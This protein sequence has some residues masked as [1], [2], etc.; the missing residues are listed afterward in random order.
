MRITRL[1]ATL[2]FTLLLSLTGTLA[3]S[4]TEPSLHQVYEAAQS[5]HLEQAQEM[6]S[7]VLK[8]HPN[9]AKAHFVRAEL[10]S[11]QGQL[12]NARA[13][14][15]TAERLAPGLP[16][17][18]ADAVRKL[19]SQLTPATSAGRLSP[20]R[21]AATPT[22]QWPWGLILLIVGGAVV[23]AV[24]VKNR[25]PSVRPASHAHMDPL[26]GPQSMG[27]PGEAMS[28]MAAAP[29]YPQPSPGMGSGVMGGLAT[30]LAVG[31][32]VMA[33]E[34]IGRSLMG[35]D[36]RSPGSAPSQA[37]DTF[38]PIVDNSAMGGRDFGVSDASS[39][40]DGNSVANADLGSDWDS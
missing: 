25:T 24:I 17:A 18:Q 21:E 22:P 40:D 16:F 30:G 14:L 4:Q 15:R 9:S 36:H 26:L 29:A 34:A 2:S 7:Q 38:E 5:G 12:E 6:M 11:R 19:R 37:F 23:I 10:F 39:W 1:L 32:G 28:P 33:A 20:Q 8:A 27:R 3:F 13:E 35:G 31:A